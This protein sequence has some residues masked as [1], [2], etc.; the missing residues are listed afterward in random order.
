[1]S[2]PKFTPGDLVLAGQ[3]CRY[4]GK[5]GWVCSM[6]P[7]PVKYCATCSARIA[8]GNAGLAELQQARNAL[9]KAVQS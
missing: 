2:A 5:P 4:R 1:M 6:L 3:P 8:I 9:G 7:S